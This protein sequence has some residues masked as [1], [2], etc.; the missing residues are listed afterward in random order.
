M[1]IL[2]IYLFSFKDPMRNHRSIKIGMIMVIEMGKEITFK[3]GMIS[4]LR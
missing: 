4:P 3:K 2:T 1:N